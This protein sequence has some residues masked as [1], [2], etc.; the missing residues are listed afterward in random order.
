MQHPAW[1]VHRDDEYVDLRQ[2]FVKQP[3]VCR[4][5]KPS[6]RSAICFTYQFQRYG[7]FNRAQYFSF[8]AARKFIYRYAPE[9][10]RHWNVTWVI[11]SLRFAEHNGFDRF[12][13]EIL[14]FL[15]HEKVYYRVGNVVERL[16]CQL[17]MSVR[18]A[19]VTVVINIII[20][21]RRVHQNHHFISLTISCLISNKSYC[22]HKNTGETESTYI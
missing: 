1:T 7:E 16:V 20:A 15:W 6:K 17:W 13:F 19:V 10:Y 4:V 22:S 3:I 11:V 9:P 5:V 14:G 12:R 21:V 8:Y 2:Y 18:V